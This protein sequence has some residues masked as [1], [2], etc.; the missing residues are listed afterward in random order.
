MAIY[1]GLLTTDM[2]GKTGGV[3]FSKGKG[4]TVVRMKNGQVRPATQFQAAAKLYLADAAQTW[5]KQTNGYRTQWDEFAATRFRSNSLGNR[6]PMT[7]FNF[8]CQSMANKNTLQGSTG[9]LPSISVLGIV[10]VGTPLITSFTAD[11]RGV[12][13]LTIVNDDPN[14]QSVWALFGRLT[15]CLSP[16]ITSV[17]RKNYRLVFLDG[18]PSVGSGIAFFAEWEPYFGSVV[19]GLQIFAEFFYVDQNTGV[20]GY[21]QSI[22]TIAVSL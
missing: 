19:P 8:F 6:S 12:G 3:V 11:T 5:A 18:D 13:E 9:N 16:G 22:S 15:G 10:P 4:G 17:P 20:A 2:R 14:Y 1:Q 7:G 21:P